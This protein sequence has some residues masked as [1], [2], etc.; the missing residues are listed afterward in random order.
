MSSPREPLRRIVVVGSGPVGVL[1]A[2]GLRR[3]LPQCEIFVVGPAPGPASFADHAPTALPFTNRLHDRLGIDEEALV[4]MAGA[5]HRLA[6][7]YLGW[8][9]AGAQGMMTY[10]SEG[11][12][13]L[14]TRFAQ[15]W[16]GGARNAS[17]DRSAD[18]SAGSLAEALAEAG[19]FA[20]PPPDQDTPLSQVEYALR[21]NP[22]AYR[23]L[24]IAHA[25][26]ARIAHV[27]G[28]IAALEPDGQGGIASIAMAGQ[29][30]IES[31][32]FIDCSGSAA[33]LASAQPGFARTDWSDVLPARRLLIAPPGQPMLALEDRFSL[34]AEGWLCELAGRD[35]LQT[36]LA[37]PDGVSDE[38][39]LRALGAQPVAAIQLAP[40]RLDNPWQG[41]VVALGDAAAQFE[42][43]GFLNLDLAHRQIDLLLEMLPGREIVPLERAEYNRRAGLMLD[44]AC[45]TL[46]LHY[47][48]PRARQVFGTPDA[49]QSVSV[50]LDQF[51]RR[52]RL[53]FQEEAPFLRQEQMR[54]LSAL[55]FAPGTAPQHRNADPRQIEAMQSEFAGRTRAALDFAPPY[56]QWMASV[57]RAGAAPPG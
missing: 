21:W 30:R 25:Q 20:S 26:Q 11:D 46:A 41:N 34:L 3:A 50:A 24:L 55:G 14:Q 35:G 44:A 45:H 18:R 4:R 28:E 43:L 48:A 10:G 40:G 56:A 37:T 1:S 36:S 53:P 9:E 13:A 23:D 49:P 17:P 2:I 39:A 32:L 15:D 47:A 51:T 27:P 54:L 7:R 8:G 12:A 33:L 52:G 16:G 29:G 31:D 57:S 42:P 22:A 5:S 6:T 38:A 19:R